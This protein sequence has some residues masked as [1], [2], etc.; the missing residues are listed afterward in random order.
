MSY[1]LGSNSHDNG[2]P[3]GDGQT[4]DAGEGTGG[5]LKVVIIIYNYYFSKFNR[6]GLLFCIELHL[7]F[8]SDIGGV[9]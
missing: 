2:N 5:E 4:G 7:Y 6:Q 3:G 8:A 9:L 1:I